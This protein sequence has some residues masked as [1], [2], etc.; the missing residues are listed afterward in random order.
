VISDRRLSVGNPI[1]LKSVEKII[2][3]ILDNG[4]SNVVYLQRSREETEE[5]EET[6][7]TERPQ[8]PRDQRDRAKPR[9]M[10]DSVFPLVSRSLRS[11]GLKKDSDYR[12]R[13]KSL[14]MG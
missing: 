11:H 8:R 7:G 9:T 1:F 2:V 12:D 4:G 14:S 10:A 6:E 13:E 5:T 3:K